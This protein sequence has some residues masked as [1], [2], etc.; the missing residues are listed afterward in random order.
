MYA[1][2]A[3]GRRAAFVVGWVEAL[4][5]YAAAIAAIGTVGGEYL[6]R[7]LGAPAGSTP[8]AT[9]GPAQ[10]SVGSLSCSPANRFRTT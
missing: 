6:G 7:L 1:R 2:E 5:M 9:R 10:C 8:A 3:F 4:G